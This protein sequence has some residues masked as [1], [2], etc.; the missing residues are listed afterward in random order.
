M[1]W[2]Y[3]QEK[4][5]GSEERNGL[6]CLAASK[7]SSGDFAAMLF[8]VGIPYYTITGVGE[9]QLTIPNFPLTTHRVEQ[10]HGLVLMD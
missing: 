5:W 4:F 7:A 9:S 2:L 1:V 10:V 6:N 8:G 3:R